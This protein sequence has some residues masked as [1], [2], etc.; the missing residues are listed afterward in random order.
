MTP[1]TLNGLA[2]VRKTRIAGD[3]EEPFDTRECRN[4]LLDRA[5]G[6][7]LLLGVAA[8]VLKREHGDRRLVGQRQWLRGRREP[9]D[10]D[11]PVSNP[12]HP[13]WSSDV[14]DLLLAQVFEG[15]IEPVPYLIAGINSLMTRFN[16]LLGANKFPVPDA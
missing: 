3:D 1:A 16:S 10:G 12:V 9:L 13:H 2:L 14:L 6:E 7:V 8:H 11:G 5:V 4:D 15:E